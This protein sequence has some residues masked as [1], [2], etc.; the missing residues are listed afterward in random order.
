MGVAL[1]SVVLLVFNGVQSGVFIKGLLKLTPE[2]GS[3][4]FGLFRDPLFNVRI[5]EL[6]THGDLV[7]QA[8]LW[9]GLAGLVAILVSVGLWKR[10]NA[11]FFL[12][13]KRPALR[14]TLIWIGAFLLIA[15]A[16]E[17]LAALTDAFSTDFMEKILKS[18][19]DLALL[20][21]GV[22]IMAPLFE[23]FLLRGLLLGSIRHLTDEHTA[24]AITAGVFA[25]MH[26]QYSWTVMLLIVPMG[27][28][29]GY[30]RT[31]SGSIWVPVLLH[32]INNSA[33][34]LLG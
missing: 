33:T 5:K 34:V 31:R 9:G 11:A 1:F 3:F 2:L 16:F 12:G 22:G 4:R 20:L 8:T 21:L 32:M 15:V 10:G 29:F 30:A 19:T 23:E 24:V 27:V 13:L 18:T 7:A 17:V 6:S 26:L 25:L 28:V 14:Q